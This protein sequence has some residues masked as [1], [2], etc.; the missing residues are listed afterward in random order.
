MKKTFSSLCLSALLLA[1]AFSA[2]KNEHTQAVLKDSTAFDIGKVKS[3]IDE[4]NKTFGE[5]IIKGDSV[6]VAA[7]YASDAHILPPNMPMVDNE[8]GIAATAAAFSK[9]GLKHFS[10]ESTHVWGN[11]DMVVEEGKYSLG[12]APD[13]TN[14]A[15]KYIV[16]WKQENGKWKIFRDIWNSNNPPPPPKKAY[17]K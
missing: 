5:A 6:T 10:I 13:K 14:D 8:K 9:M 11:A 12:F 16:V 1:L 2:C 15:G 17:K 7:L 4:S 3:V